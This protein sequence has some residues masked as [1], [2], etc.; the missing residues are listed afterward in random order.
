MKNVTINLKEN[1]FKLLLS[2][3]EEASDNRSD[4]TCNDPEES[5][6]KLFTKKERTEIGIKLA[7]SEYWDFDEEDEDAGITLTI[8]D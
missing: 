1:E 7:K 8:Y 4:M 6:E 2:I 5:E 3:L